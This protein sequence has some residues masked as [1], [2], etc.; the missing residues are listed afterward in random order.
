VRSVLIAAAIGFVAFSLQ[1]GNGMPMAL[2]IG[3]AVAAVVLL[4]LVGF[5]FLQRRAGAAS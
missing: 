5:R 2:Y 3:L 1:W 4:L